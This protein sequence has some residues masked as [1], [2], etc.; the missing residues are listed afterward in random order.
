MRE[1]SRVGQLWSP[2]ATPTRANQRRLR[3]TLVHFKSQV[4]RC[5]E[6]VVIH[7][8]LLRIEEKGAEEQGGPHRKRGLGGEKINEDG[9]S[10]V[11]IDFRTIQRGT[12]CPINKTLLLYSFSLSYA[13]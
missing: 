1:R 3:D 11:N 12:H 10:D 2:R 9:D 6:R 5:R 7:A 13:K 4:A 8:L